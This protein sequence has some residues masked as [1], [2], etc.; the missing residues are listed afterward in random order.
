MSNDEVELAAVV[1]GLKSGENVLLLGPARKL[2]HELVRKGSAELGRDCRVYVLRTHELDTE[3]QHAL[4]LGA[5]HVVAEELSVPQVFRILTEW[6]EVNLFA[7]LKAAH[8]FG[9]AFLFAKEIK[10][11]LGENSSLAPKLLEELVGSLRTVCV[12]I[13]SGP[14][15]IKGAFREKLLSARYNQV[16]PVLDRGSLLKDW[17]EEGEVCDPGWELD[18]S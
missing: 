9:A 3:K 16:R 8:G 1:N 13:S 2:I 10:E 17:S 7:S 14:P 12:P 18:R 15:V 11:N 5:T 4:S 6:P